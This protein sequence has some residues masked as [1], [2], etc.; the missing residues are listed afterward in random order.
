MT[1]EELRD[2][3][4]S[5]LYPGI[6]VE[7]R[8]DA[9]WMEAFLTVDNEEISVAKGVATVEP[10]YAAIVA[11]IGLS[12]DP[13]A[14]S[15]ELDRIDRLVSTVKDAARALGLPRVRRKPRRRDGPRTS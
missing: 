10:P 3:L 12:A 6:T 9:L 13:Y 15:T 4:S 7:I 14:A 8:H 5:R 11:H 2:S 1:L